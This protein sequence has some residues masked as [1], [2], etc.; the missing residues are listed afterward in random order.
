MS[1]TMRDSWDF[2][3]PAEEPVPAPPKAFVRS[4]F[5]VSAADRDKANAAAKEIDTLGGHNAF[6]AHL[7][8]ASGDIV[9]YICNW[10]FEDEGERG[11]FIAA[12]ASR[13][14]SVD[15]SD[16]SNPDPASDRGKA[17]REYLA[18]GYYPDS[19]SDA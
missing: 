13:E 10:Q 11:R 12:L 1:M 8:N 19:E 16:Y 14:V 9:A 15:R 17:K 3:T 6:M 5:I 18:K 7:E 4:I 2:G